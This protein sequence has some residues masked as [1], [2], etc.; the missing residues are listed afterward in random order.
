VWRYGGGDWL[1]PWRVYH[2]LGQDFRPLDDPDADPLLPRW[3]SRY[4]NLLYGMAKAAA[5]M[6]EGA[7][8]RP[9]PRKPRRKP[10]PGKP[11][12]QRTAGGVVLPTGTD[13]P[14]G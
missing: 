8:D 5:V 14:R 1:A 11:R 6:E 3:P 7:R 4:R 9:G 12:E 13:E 10:D 2:A